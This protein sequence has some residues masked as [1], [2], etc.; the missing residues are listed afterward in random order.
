MDADEGAPSQ[1]FKGHRAILAAR[2]PV[3]SNMFD[4]GGFEATTS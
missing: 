1:V 4:V 2:S 3:M